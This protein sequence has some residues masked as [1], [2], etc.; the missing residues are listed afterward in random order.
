M[1]WQRVRPYFIAV[2]CIFATAALIAAAVVAAL[3]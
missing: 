2:A 1:N 3:R